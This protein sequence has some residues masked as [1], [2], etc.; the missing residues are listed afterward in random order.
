MSASCSLALTCLAGQTEQ[1]DG[2]PEWLH[3]HQTQ[4][5]QGSQE[6]RRDS[7]SCATIRLIDYSLSDHLHS[8]LPV[9]PR[10]KETGCRHSS[11]FWTGHC[12]ERG[13]GLFCLRVLMSAVVSCL[14]RKSSSSFY[15]K[16]PTQEFGFA[17]FLF[18][19]ACLCQK[20][21]HADVNW[22][23]LFLWSKQKV[24]SEWGYL[25]TCKEE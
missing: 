23:P 10:H 19:F 12:R 24:V 20:R 13:L 14:H 21:T 3:E 15:N 1:P 16:I 4:S 18:H 22:E 17:H 9:Q 11:L 8:S 2:Q 25:T 5:V 7:E 6:E